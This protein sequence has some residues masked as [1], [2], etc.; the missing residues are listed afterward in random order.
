MLT[1]QSINYVNFTYVNYV[2]NNLNMH[3]HI[4]LCGFQTNFQ[5]WIKHFSI[6][7]EKLNEDPQKTSFLK[8]ATVDK[9]N[10]Q[11][12]TITVNFYHHNP[13]NLQLFFAST[14]RFS[15]KK[16]LKKLFTSTKLNFR[17]FSLTQTR[18][19]HSYLKFSPQPQPM[20]HL[21][22]LQLSPNPLVLRDSCRLPQLPLHSTVL[23]ASLPFSVRTFNHHVNLNTR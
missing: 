15:P 4:S 19:L 7:H 8:T 12:D 14:F 3:Q 5:F 13:L 9:E 6:F 21:F 18:K 16:A 1:I 17:F 23:Q 10:R 2:W 20:R 22:S 11:P